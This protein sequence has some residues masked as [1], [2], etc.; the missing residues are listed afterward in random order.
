MTKNMNTT[1]YNMLYCFPILQEYKNS[2]QFLNNFHTGTRICVKSDQSLKGI[3][4]VSFKIVLFI[5]VKKWKSKFLLP[6]SENLC[7]TKC[8]S[9]LSG[10]QIS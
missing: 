10:K 4:L 7:M 2:E 8:S 3:Y 6:L 9:T 1:F 5:Y